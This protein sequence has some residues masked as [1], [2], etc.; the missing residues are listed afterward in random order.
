MAQIIRLILLTLLAVSTVHSLAIGYPY[1]SELLAYAPARGQFPVSS[2]LAQGYIRYLDANGVERLVGYTYPE[3]LHGVRRLSYGNEDIVQPLLKFNVQSGDESDATRLRDE[4]F[5][6]WYEQRYQALK[7]ERER[8]RAEGKIPSPD[9]LA[10]LIRLEQILFESNQM[11]NVETPEVKLAREEHLR[12][13]N[14]A[15]LKVTQKEAEQ[16]KLQTIKENNS[17]EPNKLANTGELKTYHELPAIVGETAEQKKAREEHLRIYNEHLLRIKQ[18]EDERKAAMNLVKM[19]EPIK[20]ETVNDAA[21]PSQIVVETPEVSL[22]KA[23]HFRLWN[24]A[25]LRAE[26]ENIE[27][28]NDQVTIDNAKNPLIS[29]FKA[30]STGVQQNV[31][32][33]Q[34]NEANLKNYATTQQFGASQKPV[35][36]TPEV[37]RAR[38]EHLRLV[39]EAKLK[40]AVIPS[41]NTDSVV[42]PA[43]E[44][45]G[46]EMQQFASLVGNVPLTPLSY[47]VPLLKGEQT[48]ILQ[49]NEQVQYT[50]EVI[51]A[52]EEHLKLLQEAKLKSNEYQKN[53]QIA[54]ADNQHDYR[55]IAEA[56]KLRAVEHM[57]EEQMFLEAERLREAER[58][59]AEER[60]R[61]AQVMLESERQEEEERAMIAERIRLQEEEAL[62]RATEKEAESKIYQTEQQ[63]ILKATQPQQMAEVPQNLG[64]VKSLIQSAPNLQDNKL[65]YMAPLPAQPDAAIASDKYILGQQKLA[66]P[67]TTGYVLLASAPPNAFHLKNPFLL[68]YTNAI[69]GINVVAQKQQLN[70]KPLE[71]SPQLYE[72]ATLLPENQSAA[73]KISYGADSGL[74]ELEKATREHFR[75]HE[76]ALEQLRIANLRDAQEKNCN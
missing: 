75:A 23:E 47:S 22:A 24:E 51:R 29:D 6:I 26:K 74:S 14:E 36:D 67:Q 46:S 3:P 60:E 58:V 59:R 37:I 66:L 1:R 50:P 38:E 43:V 16:Q 41:P 21:Q 2:L 49:Q 73:I 13:W 40:A 53:E 8:L 28:S 54:I 70:N 5:R 19:V 62:R 63:V 69:N 11:P 35:Q 48:N 39:N 72:K 32:S 18:L 7:L 68:R 9:M 25:K 20:Q 12:L 76:I 57:K 45:K 55:P 52:R 17:Q 10:Q 31:Q 65:P 34:Q 30:I 33:L 61:I 56:D 71:I 4:H 64:I 42:I 15:R 44:S 27:Q